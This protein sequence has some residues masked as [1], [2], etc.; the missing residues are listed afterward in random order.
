VL[1]FFEKLAPHL[2]APVYPGSVWLEHVD[3]SIFDNGGRGPHGRHQDLKLLKDTLV[4]W[5]IEK[6]AFL[7]AEPAPRPVVVESEPTE[8]EADALLRP[9]I[10]K[11]KAEA[12]LI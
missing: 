11:A 1:Q 9:E 2:S 3:P 5:A 7:D 10:A 6:P 8:E 4:G 12:T